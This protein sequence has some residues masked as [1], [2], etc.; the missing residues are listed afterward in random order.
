MGCARC[1]LVCWFCSS[2]KSKDVVSDTMSAVWHFVAMLIRI[3]GI[4]MGKQQ[5]VI[6]GWRVTG[7]HASVTTCVSADMK[8]IASY[9]HAPTGVTLVGSDYR[10][11]AC[12]HSMTPASLRCCC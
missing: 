1:A 3:H 8:R 7:C 9:H 12:D 2:A 6:T 5:H 10:S 4:C 11:F